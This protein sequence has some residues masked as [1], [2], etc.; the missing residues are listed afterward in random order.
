M[1]KT[2]PL[3]IPDYLSHMLD[4]IKRIFDYIDDIDEVNFLQNKMVQDAV[5]RNLEVLGEASRN[6]ARYHPDFVRQHDELP[7]DNMYWMRNRISHGYFS[8]NFEII[9]NTIEKELPLL[10]QQ[11][12]VIYK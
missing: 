1:T 9:W 7:W 4:A 6:L 2:D 5:L 12:E 8:V 3:R 11:L 10:R